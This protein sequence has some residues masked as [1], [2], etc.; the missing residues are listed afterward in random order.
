MF[1]VRRNLEKGMSRRELVAFDQGLA[2]FL[3]QDQLLPRLKL[4]IESDY[5]ELNAGKQVV[6]Q[7]KES[8]E[9]FEQQILKFTNKQRHYNKSIKNDNAQYKWLSY[10]AMLDRKNRETMYT[11]EGMEAKWNDNNFEQFYRKELRADI[12]RPA[13]SINPDE[14]SSKKYWETGVPEF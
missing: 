10:S 13:R 4:A 3:Q 5:H 1:D 7:A 11:A 9:D 14:Y 2:K 12:K 6:E 8:E